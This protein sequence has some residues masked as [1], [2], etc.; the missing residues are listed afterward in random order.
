MKQKKWVALLLCTGFIFFATGCQ[1]DAVETDEFVAYEH[2]SAYEY[3]QDEYNQTGYNEETYV[4][5]ETPNEVDLYEEEEPLNIYGL[6]QF[7]LTILHTNDWH[8]ILHNVP[9]YATIVNEVRA[10]RENV[11]LLD[12][13]DIYRR[14]PFEALHGATE[15]AIMNAMGYDALAFGNND[16][17]RNDREFFHVSQHPMLQ[18]ANFPILLGNTT[19]DGEIVE[20]F[21]PYIIVTKQDIN[22]AIIG[23]TSPKPWDRNFDFTT[24]YLFEDPVLAVERMTEEVYEKSDI[25]IVLSHAGFE[26]DRQMCGV[27]AVIGGDDHRVLRQPYV[28]NVDGRRVPVV[29]AG[30]ERSHFLGRL[31]LYFVEIDEVWILH[32]FNGQLLNVADVTPDQEIQDIINYYRIIVGLEPILPEPL[33]PAA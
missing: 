6:N 29:Q 10:E 21:E 26:F 14:G 7:H 28:I 4:P 32:D 17:P 18:Y 1:S 33:E 2:S 25:Q 27:S 9:R 16:F 8:G 30:G 12:G 13:G 15:I 20:G 11:L 24:R 22:I 31:D 5:E 23:V 3:S 19:L